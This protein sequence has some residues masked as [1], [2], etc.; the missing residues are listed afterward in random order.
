VGVN[1]F[2]GPA[3]QIAV[4][5]RVVVEERR[6]IEEKRY[7]HALN[8]CMVL[9]GPEALQLAVYLGWV[10]N[11]VTGGLLAG[12][13]FVVP[14]LVVMAL[15]AGIY[16]AFGDVSWISAMLF[17]IQAAVIAIVIQAVIRVGRRSLRTPLLV[18]LAVGSFVA[19]SLFDVMFPYVVV[20][21]LFI[22]WVVG[23]RSP[24]A[25]RVD[26]NVD[27]DID[28][29]QPEKA[30]GARRAGIAALVIWIVPLALIIAALGT[31]N[32][33]SQEA[34]LFA[35]TAVLSFGGAYAALAYVSQQAVGYYGWIEPRDMVT[36]LGLAETT[37]G[38]LVL[39]MTFVGYVG[40][41]RAAD[42]LGLPALV[43][44][45]LGFMIAA[46]ATFVPS[47]G[48]VLLGA[49]SVE[50]LRHNRRVAGALAA[51]TAAV[52][53]VIADLALWFSLTVLFG[54]LPKRTWGPI[55]VEV[56]HLSQ[57]DWWALVLTGLSLVL[58]FRWRLGLLR[59]IGLAA[60]SGL[61]LWALGLHP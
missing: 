58:V 57:L 50:S 55:T 30:R 1:S 60:A 25:L 20:A 17:G 29:V 14:G 43:A 40:A 54:E 41:Y 3:G 48:F 16:A 23:R 61:V 33:L 21:A 37:P 8:F 7:L 11:G 42:D 24:S 15:L 53:G 36:G 52:V 6:W 59:V 2:G 4:M 28:R 39:V 46:W 26:V 9:P 18:G 51:V 27:D 13:L 19:L 38:P 47:F 49:P 34:W 35:K 45:L 5:H 10:L 44:G 56:P 22:G 31:D 32:V 12:V